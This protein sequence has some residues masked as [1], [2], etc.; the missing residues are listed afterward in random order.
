[1]FN[2]TIQRGNYSEITD[3]TVHIVLRFDEFAAVH[4]AR[5]RLARHNVTFRLV[6]NLDRHADRHGD[7]GLGRI[8]SGCNR[9]LLFSEFRFMFATGS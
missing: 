1:M 8:Q 7:G 2:A 9:L 6:Q 5:V 4:L 3:L